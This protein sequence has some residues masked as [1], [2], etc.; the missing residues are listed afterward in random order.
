MKKSINETG[1]KI[2]KF[3]TIGSLDK[4]KYYAIGSSDIS[5][6]FIH[7]SFMYIRI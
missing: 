4:K 3:I 7:L 5:N 2:M 1:K 6:N